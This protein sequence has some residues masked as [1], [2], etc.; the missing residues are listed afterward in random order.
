MTEKRN[1][2]YGRA[3][4]KDIVNGF[5]MAL[6]ANSELDHA[7]IERESKLYRDVHADAQRAFRFA[8]RRVTAEIWRDAISD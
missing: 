1:D 6:R 2:A 4:A 3:A 5:N 8:K 7:F